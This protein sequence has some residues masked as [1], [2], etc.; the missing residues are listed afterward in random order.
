MVA[1]EGLSLMT[2]L[3]D[4]I[5]IINC[6]HKKK[7]CKVAVVTSELPGG[8]EP[9]EI[10]LASSALPALISLPYFHGEPPP[11]NQSLMV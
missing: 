4:Q 6:V 11:L 7:L 2:E 9:L 8:L 3:S 1:K 10:S 5:K